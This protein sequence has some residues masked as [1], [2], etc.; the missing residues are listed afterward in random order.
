[1]LRWILDHLNSGCVG[2]L[3][4]GDITP[5]DTVVLGRRASSYA[6]AEDAIPEGQKRVL[7]VSIAGLFAKARERGV[8]P[9]QEGPADKVQRLADENGKM[10]TDFHYAYELV[11]ILERISD[12][13]FVLDAPSI[14]GR[15]EPQTLDLLQ[16]ATRCYLF[17]LHRACLAICRTELEDS[18]EQRVPQSKLLQEGLQSRNAGKLDLLINAAARDGVLPSDLRSVAHDIRRHANG[19]LHDADRDVPDPWQLLLHTRTIVE[20]VHTRPR[21][22]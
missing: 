19:V 20:E 6:S 1:M 12:K 5:A 2:F 8:G 16:E 15:A 7:A 22:S 21:S 17:G 10:N 4:D 13:T 11:D 9:E 18:L 3:G 14:V